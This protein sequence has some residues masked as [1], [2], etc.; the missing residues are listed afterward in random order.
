MDEKYTLKI[1]PAAYN[2]IESVLKYLSMNLTN[3]DA[4]ANLLDEIEN[5]MQE[6]CFFPFSYPDCSYYFLAEKGYRHVLVGSYVLFFY[7][8]EEAHRVEVLRFLYSGRDFSRLRI[9]QDG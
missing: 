1:T 7:V 2:D 6:I 8:R 4:A 9:N 3:P 5:K